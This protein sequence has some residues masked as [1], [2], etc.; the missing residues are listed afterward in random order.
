MAVEIHT[1]MLGGVP[2]PPV[3]QKMLHFDR[4]SSAYATVVGVCCAARDRLW[5]SVALSFG[6]SVYPW[7]MDRR[8]QLA[9][10]GA[11]YIAS[12]ELRRNR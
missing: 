11:S 7:D 2:V 4:P 8:L 6:R 5:R 9:A 1:H 3:G 10:F 12:E